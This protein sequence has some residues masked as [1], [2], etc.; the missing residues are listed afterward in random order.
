MKSKNSLAVPIIV[1]LI[2]ISLSTLL[3]GYYVNLQSLN[4]SL[5]SRE[6]DKTSYVHFIINSI[7]NQ[8]IEKL[9][10]LSKLL[11]D[12][13]D[14]ATSLIYYESF[15]D[16]ES[17]KKIMDRLF[18]QMKV[19]ILDAISTKGTLIYCGDGNQIEDNEYGQIWG[20][21]EALEGKEVLAVAKD[22]RGWGIRAFVPIRSP[23]KLKGVI[24]V[25]F[26]IDDPFAQ[27][28]AAATSSHV[29]LA[30]ASG[31][32]AS[33]LIPGKKNSI[34]IETIKRSLWERNPI[35]IN[36]RAPANISRYAPLRVVDE[37]FCLIVQTD[38]RAMHGLLVENRKIL[39]FI[40]IAVLSVVILVAIAF[41][42]Y[43]IKPLKRLKKNALQIVK[44]Y[45]GG[46]IEVLTSGNEIQTLE[47][48][49]H[50]LLETIHKHLAER[51]LTEQSLGE[52][53]RKFRDLYDNAPL[54]YHEYDAEGRIT[55]VNHTDLV[56]LGYTA[57][58]MIG[59]FMW[60]FNVEEEMAREQIL[61]KLAGTL[62]PGRNLE[63]TYRRKDGTTF[64][65][66]IED[67]L[68]L[69]EKG[70]IQG[71][72]C[73]IQDITDR[74]KVEKE[75]DRLAQENAIMAE[76]GQVISSTLNIEEVYERFAEEAHKLIP[77]DRIGINIKNF[78][79]DAVTAVYKA[80]IEVP[81]RQVGKVFSLAGTVA[82]EVLR[83][84]SSLLISPHAMEDF[85]KRFPGY[86]P[87][88]QAGLRSLMALPL[89][90]RD[91][92]IGVL[93]I[94]SLKE[95]AYT[96]ED[97]RIAEKIG[98]Q[99][100]GA[101][102]SAQLFTE[103]KRAEGKLRRS[104]EILEMRVQERTED[105]VKARDAAEAANRAKS[106]FLANM[107]HELRTPL[108]HIIGFTELVVDKQ[109]GELNEVQEEYLNDVLQ[110]SRHL[111]SLINDILDLSKVEAGKLELQMTEVHLRILLESSLSMVKEKA[112]KHMI[113]LLTDIDGIPEAIQA[114]ERKLKQ[115]LY[116]LLSNA[117]KFTPDGGSVTL[118]AWYLSFRDGQWVTG[119]REAVFWPLD[120]DDKLRKGGRLIGI[121]VQD[122]GIGIKW[123]DLERIFDPFEQGDNSASRRYQGTGLGLSLTKRL[124][125][126][127][128]GRIWAE[129][130]GEGRGSKFTLVIPV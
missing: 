125:E 73:T 35:S 95:N 109:C 13:Q 37:T 51:K 102:A 49:H 3:I 55:N 75:L 90:S 27:K 128:E 46:K 72:R 81:S 103:R 83:T 10:V 8:E 53:D 45:S 40:S 52:S 20:I 100:A 18:S 48:A 97:L 12:N 94:S 92:V 99:I 56:M 47:Q 105:L 129:S 76:I 67:R 127:Q 104:Q 19:Q 66:L 23:Q 79:E 96:E 4:D 118:S 93:T 22:L 9:A 36:D 78:G 98:T 87:S 80:G 113:Q 119:G 2:L 89:F 108:N 91:E 71:I 6:L 30:T 33:S 116:N 34:D 84:R 42:L 69:D 60:K 41:I 1:F 39:F 88:Y 65:V 29:S 123:E 70:Q 28:I 63:R 61:A 82:E 112:M 68:I 21:D 58:E 54:G 24:I 38:T 115:I 122:T 59:Q 62:P 25:G 86:L 11:K 120:K 17:L 32:F 85:V 16:S 14:L 117:V 101:I 26:M 110:S 57:E 5:E 74:K 50:L 44:E 124:V 43:L 7:I 126:L 130:E 64:P 15:E 107:S 114:D 111:L 121:S 106:E 77:F 31:V